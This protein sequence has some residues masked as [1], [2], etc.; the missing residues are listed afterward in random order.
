MMIWV[1]T[2]IMLGPTG[3][4]FHTEEFSTYEQCR[5]AQKYWQKHEEVWSGNC[6]KRNRQ[7]VPKTT[8]NHHITS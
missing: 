7:V 2:L 6:R 8:D 1:L 3:L 4:F 5:E